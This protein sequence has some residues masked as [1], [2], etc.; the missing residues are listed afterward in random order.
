MNKYLT[1]TEII[2]DTTIISAYLWH[3]TYVERFK[4]E[5]CFCKNMC[6]WKINIW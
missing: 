6:S 1:K 5:D 4:K 3:F 2:Y